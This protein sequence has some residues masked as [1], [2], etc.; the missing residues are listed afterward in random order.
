MTEDT[1]KNC[2][3]HPLESLLQVCVEVRTIQTER[4]PLPAFARIRNELR[5]KYH[6]C[7]HMKKVGNTYF[8]KSK[9]KTECELCG[10]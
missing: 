1:Q 8:Q 6:T 7:I 9:S 3:A 10:N 4:I 2:D 5:E